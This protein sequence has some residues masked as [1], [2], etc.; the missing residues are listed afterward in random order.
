MK[1]RLPLLALAILAPCLLAQEPAEEKPPH[2]FPE[3]SLAENNDAFV[4]DWYAKH[5]KAMD[6]TPLPEAAKDKKTAVYRFTVLPTFEHPYLVKVL[7][8]DGKYMMLRKLQSGRGGYEAGPLKEFAKAE[9]TDAKVAELD[10]LLADVKFLEMPSREK[11]TG[12][13]GSRWILEVVKDGRYHFV[14]RWSPQGDSPMVKLHA[15][16]LEVARWTPPA[17]R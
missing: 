12:L 4:Q 16:F 2:Y 5:L 17:G 3:G 6:E 7:K 10:K 1:T 14:D 11:N 15:W 8:I 13:D 9:L